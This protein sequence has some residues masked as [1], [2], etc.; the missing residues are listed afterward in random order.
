MPK[1]WPRALHQIGN[2]RSKCNKAVTNLSTQQL[3]PFWEVL[4]ILCCCLAWNW[5]HQEE[6]D[7]MLVILF[8]WRKYRFDPSILHASWTN[9]V[10]AAEG[11]FLKI[12]T[13]VFQFCISNQCLVW[14]CIW[15]GFFV[16]VFFKGSLLSFSRKMK[17]FS[18]HFTG[19][20]EAFGFGSGD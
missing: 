5:G 13:T 14:K 9:P 20:T 15:K 4:G 17:H 3:S 6:G 8:F 10:I 1:P 11:F 12:L 2:E 7:K 19:K 18:F 16:F